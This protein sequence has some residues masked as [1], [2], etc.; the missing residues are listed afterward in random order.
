MFFLFLTCGHGIRVVTAIVLAV[1]GAVVVPRP[2]G[3]INFDLRV[4]SLL[5]LFLD[6]RAWEGCSQNQTHRKHTMIRVKGGFR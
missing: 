3:N 1:E 2:G 5:L 6:E 4:V